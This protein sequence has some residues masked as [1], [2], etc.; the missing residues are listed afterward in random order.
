[1]NIGIDMMGGDFAPVEAVKGVLAY[2]TTV[3][4]P[5]HIIGFGD[6]AVLSRC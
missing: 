1:M 2:L 4:S 6:E 5:S 3:N